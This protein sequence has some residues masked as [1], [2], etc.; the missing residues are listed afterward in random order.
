MWLL[1]GFAD[2][3]GY[4]ESGLSLA[5]GAPDLAELVAASGPPPALPEDRS[6]RAEGTELDLAYQQA[7]SVARFIAERHGEAALVALYR[8]LAGAGPVSAA[9]TDDLLREAIGLDR[10]ALQAQWREHLGAALG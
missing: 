2:Y 10:A 9:R 8:S 5:Q 1:E 6:F 3:V 7:W 4:R